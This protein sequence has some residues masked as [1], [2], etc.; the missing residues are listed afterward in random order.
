MVPIHFDLAI[1]DFREL[2]L[3]II[4]FSNQDLDCVKSYE[5]V[6]FYD[7]SSYTIDYCA[8]YR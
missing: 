5:G 2:N 6:R 4:T 8:S 7:Y 1:P 3:L